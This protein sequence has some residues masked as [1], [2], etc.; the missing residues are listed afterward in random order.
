M[1]DQIDVQMKTHDYNH[2]AIVT[3]VQT[4]LPHQAT[5]W[6]RFLKTGPLAFLP[7]QNPNT[8]SIVW[9]TVPEHA[10]EL[11]AMDEVEFRNALCDAFESRLGG[12]IQI[13]KR[14]HFPLQMRHA[15]NYVKEHIA[16]IG[17]A[18]H[19]IHPLAGQGVNLGL[20]DALCLVETVVDAVNKHRNYASMTT[21]RRYE[22][23]RKGDNLAMLAMVEMLKS[24]FMSDKALVKNFRSFG[25]NFTDRVSFLKNFFA[26]YALGNRGDLP[27]LASNWLGVK[28]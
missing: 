15:K 25:L 8:S 23:W 17:D 3:T 9:S 14:Y 1:R 4:E 10:N 11:L 13:D 16:L 6:Q 24:L 7:L 26:K 27:K 28:S 12:I 19:T 2:I 21:L 5:A 20:L 22:R 18:A